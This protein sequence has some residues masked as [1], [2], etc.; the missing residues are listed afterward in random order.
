MAFFDLSGKDTGLNPVSTPL[1]VLFSTGAGL[2]NLDPSKGCR[3]QSICRL[4][5]TAFYNVIPRSEF[6]QILQLS[7]TCCN[8]DCVGLSTLSLS[9]GRAERPLP[10]MLRQAT[11]GMFSFR[12][13]QACH[14]EPVEGSRVEAFA[15]YAST[16]SA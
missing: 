9:K 2:S 7:M 3:G 1:Y 10:T 4:N 8:F 14:P 12:G 16:G 11:H 5:V 15:H 6:R 13:A